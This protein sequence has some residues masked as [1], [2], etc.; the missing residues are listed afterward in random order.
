[1]ATRTRFVT[2]SELTKRVT[3]P[4]TRQKAQPNSVCGCAGAARMGARPVGCIR[5]RIWLAQHRLWKWIMR[6]AELIHWRKGAETG[7]LEIFRIVRLCANVP[8]LINRSRP[9]EQTSSAPPRLSPEGACITPYCRPNRFPG[10][11]PPQVF[12]RIDNSFRTRVRGRKPA[13][14]RP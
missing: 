13:D 10:S 3:G 11:L 2:R 6:R 4:K 12:S 5:A 14:W 1:M 8:R 7:R 9:A